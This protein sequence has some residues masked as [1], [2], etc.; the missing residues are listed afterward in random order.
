MR[1]HA[2]GGYVKHCASEVLVVKAGGGAYLTA[3]LISIRVARQTRRLALQ[4]WGDIIKN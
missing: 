1:T 3:D 4:G 2:H